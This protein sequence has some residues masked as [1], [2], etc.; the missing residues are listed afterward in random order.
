MAR[1]ADALRVLLRVGDEDVLAVDG[2]ADGLAIEQ[3]GR[4]ALG[5]LGELAG[6][7]PINAF[8][9]P[10]PGVAGKRRPAV[11]Q[12]IKLDMNRLR[13][14][15]LHGHEALLVA[16]EVFDEPLHVGERPLA[17]GETILVT[18]PVGELAREDIR[19]GSRGD[20]LSFLCVGNWSERGRRL[21]GSHRWARRLRSLGWSNDGPSPR[22]SGAGN[23]RRGL[24]LQERC[25]FF[26]RPLERDL[27]TDARV[28]GA[29]TGRVGERK[30][31][32]GR[33]DEQPSFHFRHEYS[34]VRRLVPVR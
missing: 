23:G 18:E 33:C 13:A 28:L 8:L 12:G 4:R 27:D 29:S 16:H 17:K 2:R 24:R 21:R 25:F 15:G 5:E 10:C 32:H 30:A 3:R 14:P 11:E 9:A 22:R 1:T 34:S 26:Y 7:Q 19:L 6:Q 31:H 20:D